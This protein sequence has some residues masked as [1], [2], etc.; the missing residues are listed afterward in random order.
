MKRVLFVDDDPLI[1]SGLK[2]VLRKYRDDWK[3]EY[4]RSGKLAL[5]FLQAC[6]IDA[7]VADMRMPDMDGA[8]LLAIVRDDFPHVIRVML[9]GQ[10]DPEGIRRAALVAHQYFSKPCDPSE[11]LTAL[12]RSCRLR[13]Q[14]S[15]TQLRD[16]IS[17][18]ASL[19]FVKETHRNL[20][21]EL[22][23]GDAS[24]DRIAKLVAADIGLSTKL[25]QLVNSSF[26]GRSFHIE[27]VQQAAS[28][29]GLSVLKPTIL[30]F[31][32]LEESSTPE[33]QLFSL[34]EFTRHSLRV[35]S[36]SRTIAK[37][38]RM[39]KQV[40]DDAHVAGVLHGVGKLV[41]AVELGTEYDAILQVAETESISLPEAE[42]KAL[43]TTHAE[44]G[45][46]L[47]GLWGLP[48]PIVD[49]VLYHHSPQT[50]GDQGAH[51]L[52]ALHIA[53]AINLDLP[54][55]QSQPGLSSLDSNFYDRFDLDLRLNGWR[56]LAESLALEG[57]RP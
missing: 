38:L 28:M 43:G 49:S 29:L 47:L 53:N 18:S 4:A 55:L 36:L 2:R 54:D 37:D 50:L 22:N 7:I 41:L 27:G 44:L 34:E 19:P 1:L 30:S 24:I 21:N 46:M 8:E 25:L 14:I 42:N 32:L 52:V 33:T 10:S 35:G 40:I 51:P 20:L 48:D 17:R 12:T 45:A 39:P 57:T 13:E 31:A 3:A 16:A 23:S 9:S 11:L 56:E 6:P 26:F 15:N 5:S